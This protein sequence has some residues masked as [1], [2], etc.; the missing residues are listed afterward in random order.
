MEEGMPKAADHTSLAL[1]AT[2][3][4]LARLRTWW[5]Y[6]NEL[7]G[8][9]RGEVDRIAADLGMTARDLEDLVARGP[10]AAA[11]LYQRMTALGLSRS[12][13]ERTASGLM[14]D[15]ERT[16][17]CCDHKGVCEKDLAGRPEDP[18]WRSYCSNAI[19]LNSVA[20]RKGRFPA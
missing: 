19:S 17:T 15:L 20:G 13:V 18:A 5:Q 8:M 6:Y 16:C 10:D 1:K 7:G 9:D 12:D 11:L 2:E 14:R 4:F 3:D